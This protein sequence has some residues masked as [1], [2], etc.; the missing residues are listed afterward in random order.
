MV[1]ECFV[2]T[3]LDVSISQNIL[4]DGLIL[5]ALKYYRILNHGAERFFRFEIS[6][7]TYA[8]GLRQL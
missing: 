1:Y 4:T 2:F 7:N 8:L 3:G 6:S 5:T